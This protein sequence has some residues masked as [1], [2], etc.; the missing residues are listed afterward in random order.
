MWLLC[1][2]TEG[3]TMKDFYF[4]FGHGQKHFPSHV[5]ITAKDQETARKKMVETYG[6]KWSMVYT[7]FSEVHPYDQ[8]QLAHLKA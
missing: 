8:K 1:A 3:E 5:R 6:T 4:T 7:S 2:R